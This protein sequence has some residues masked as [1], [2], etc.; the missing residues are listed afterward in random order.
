[1]VAFRPWLRGQAH[2]CHGRGSH[3]GR[4]ETGCIV[5][6]PWTRQE[7]ERW[8]CC[9]VR[10]LRGTWSENGDIL[11]V[12]KPVTVSHTS[13]AT[14]LEPGACGVGWQHPGGRGAASIR[15]DVQQ[16]CR[17]HATGAQRHPGHEAGARLSEIPRRRVGRL[18][19]RSR[20]VPRP[21]NTTATDGC[22]GVAAHGD[23]PS[24]GRG[25]CRHRRSLRVM[26][27]GG[28][29]LAAIVKRRIV[30]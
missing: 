12:S 25:R 9:Q 29:E 14:A 19:P 13:G 24:F 17:Q 30:G 21:A 23:H 27:F 10:R 3:R 8:H 2:L 16:R 7:P 15:R 5:H 26:P 4:S 6:D 11:L 18:V 28:G 20:V 22:C 1:M